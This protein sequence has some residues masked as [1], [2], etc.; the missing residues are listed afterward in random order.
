VEASIQA[1]NLIAEFEGFRANAYP[2]PATG[3]E[4]W[5]IGYGSTMYHDGVKVIKGDEI[6]K[7]DALK[8]LEFEVHDHIEPAVNAMLRTQVSQEQFD[9]LVCFAYNVGVGN[10]RSST[11]LKML[12]AGED[13][14]EVAKQFLRWNRAAGRVMAG[15]TRRRQAEADLFLA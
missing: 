2:D 4:P 5:T 11:L 7:E 10:L 3:D 14:E 9:A 15:L 8:E 1:A 12:N 6:S 13:P